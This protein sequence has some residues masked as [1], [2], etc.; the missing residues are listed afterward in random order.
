M[1]LS[2]RTFLE[3]MDYY[4]KRL[5]AQIEHCIQQ[6]TQLTEQIRTLRK[7]VEETK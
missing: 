2:F 4:D 5:R 3:E 7:L 1:E 6:T